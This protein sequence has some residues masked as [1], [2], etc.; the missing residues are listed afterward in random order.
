MLPD[1]PLRKPRPL[2]A[3]QE[4]FAQLVASGLTQSD[5]YRQAYDTSP[6]TSPNTAWTNGSDLAHNA[7]VMLRIAELKAAYQKEMVGAQAWN[8]DR[9][10]DE[11]AINLDLSREYK[12]LGSANGALEIIGRATGL[13]S[14][15][16]QNQP[17]PAITRVVVVLQ[18][19]GGQ[20]VIEAGYTVPAAIEAG[21]AAS[22]VEEA[23]VDD[24]K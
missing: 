19:T 14:D 24:E 22:M 6:D 1:Q 11:A 9:I 23:S 3:K 2:T 12:Q 7:E 21:D 17:L 18:G 4:H 10:V 16:Q 5:A 20:Q 13:L 8:L 15:K